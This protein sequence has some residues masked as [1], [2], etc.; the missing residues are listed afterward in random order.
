MQTG[1]IPQASLADKTWV[2]QANAVLD[3]I[4]AG[5][6]IDARVLNSLRN[7]RLVSASPWGDAAVQ[8]RVASFEK[9]II[10]TKGRKKQIIELTWPHEGKE[11]WECTKEKIASTGMFYNPPNADEADFATCQY[12]Q[13]G[14]DGWEANDDPIFEHRKRSPDCIIFKGPLAL[15][16][17]DP[18]ILESLASESEPEAKPTKPTKSTASS[19]ATTTTA[20]QEN[21]PQ[22]PKPLSKT[23]KRTTHGPVATKTTKKSAKHVDGDK[24]LPDAIE[25]IILNS[26]ETHQS[27]ETPA[28][29]AETVA[30][31]KTIPA[32]TATSSNKRA[33]SEE[34]E[35]DAINRVSSGKQAPPLVEALAIE[36]LQ[37]LPSPSKKQKEAM[38]YITHRMPR[39]KSVVDRKEP[40]KQQLPLQPLKNPLPHQK[41][42]QRMKCVKMNMVETKSLCLELAQLLQQP[43]QQLHQERRQPHHAQKHEVVLVSLPAK[44]TKAAKP[45]PKKRITAAEK[46][47]AALAEANIL[48]QLTKEAAG[49]KETTV[50]LDNISSLHSAAPASEPLFSSAAPKS[51]LVK[52][53]SVPTNP[54]P[55]TKP[56]ADYT[57]M[58]DDL[59]DFLH[60]NPPPLSQPPAEEPPVTNFVNPKTVENALQSSSTSAGNLQRNKSTDNDNDCSS[61]SSDSDDLLDCYSDAPTGFETQQLSNQSIQTH[62]TLVQEPAIISDNRAVDLA[63]A[64][65]NVLEKQ[66]TIKKKEDSN[67]KE[68]QITLEEPDDIVIEL[69]DDGEVE[70]GEEDDDEAHNEPDDPLHQLLASVLGTEA[71][72]TNVIQNLQDLTVEERGMTVEAYLR[73]IVDRECERIERAGQGIV[74]KM[75]EE[76][77]K[78]RKLI[79]EMNG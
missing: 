73:H 64:E 25:D 8:S 77:G 20:E 69:D 49:I 56:K 79:E 51:N 58:I 35:K 66:S 54:P 34:V 62:Q 63:V 65:Q 4:L 22:K 68:Q 45:P 60:Q 41:P 3:K 13:L 78:V 18:K 27:S 43:Q 21:S 31:E 55:P 50:T 72:A 6:K 46:K 29:V 9:A 57:K 11:N 48:T 15:A 40:P 39:I 17:L 5:N 53:S 30:V 47:A 24:P 1:S 42:Q 67:R 44:E 74:D 59:E 19:S 14:L 52:Q 7:L 26:V 12:C 10:Q 23:S 36:S 70:E 75:M 76:T 28:P 16:K 61:A 32:P 33:T 2:R 38:Q 71:S 37:I